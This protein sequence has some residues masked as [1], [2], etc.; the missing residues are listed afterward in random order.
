MVW[1]AMVRKQVTWGAMGEVH[2]HWQLRKGYTCT[3]GTVHGEDH[4][5]WCRD[6]TGSKAWFFVTTK[7]AKRSCQLD[8]DRNR[9]LYGP[10]YS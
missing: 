10:E 8:S 1:S 6:M 5:L 3:L 7:G 4:N 9:G 2:H